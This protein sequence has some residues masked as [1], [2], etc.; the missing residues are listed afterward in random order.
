MGGWFLTFAIE[1][2]YSHEQ[3][4]RLVAHNHCSLESPTV[5]ALTLAASK[6]DLPLFALLLELGADPNFGLHSQTHSCLLKIASVP[7]L[8]AEFFRVLSKHGADLSYSHLTMIRVLGRFFMKDSVFARV[9]QQ[10][11]QSGDDGAFE[12]LAQVADWARVL[13]GS[14][15]EAWVRGQCLKDVVAAESARKQATALFV[16]HSLLITQKRRLV[17]APPFKMAI[18]EY[19]I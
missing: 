13:D 17:A 19:L 12:Y 6:R 18:A 4:A 10:V 8:P 14:S 5:S 15:L 2:G 7:S 1:A 11:L 3:L 16:Y 9:Y